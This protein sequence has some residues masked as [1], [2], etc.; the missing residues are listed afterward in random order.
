[1]RAAKVDAN[2]GDVVKGLR[3]VGIW[4]HSTAGL[5]NGFPDILACWRGVFVLLE[6]KDGAKSPSQRALT[7]AE[8]KFFGDCPGPVF[9]VNHPTE[10]INAV[11][12]HASACSTRSTGA[13]RDERQSARGTGGV[14]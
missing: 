9:V 7:P 3:A 13:P 8:A 6:V 5:G 10:A 14:K 11:T 4:A 12:G 1:M 2:H